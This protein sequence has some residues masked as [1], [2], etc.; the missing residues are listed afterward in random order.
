MN[1]LFLLI[2]TT[3]LFYGC[4]STYI[5]QN[6]YLADNQL[7]SKLNEKQ[8]EITL[9]NG[10]IYIGSIIEVNSNYAAWYNTNNS[11]ESILQPTAEIHSITLIDRS[12]GMGTGFGYGFL[13]GALVGGLIGK[14]NEKKGGG[15]GYGPNINFLRGPG[16]TAFGAI[17]GGIC[18]GILGASYGTIGGDRD[19]Y[20]L[21]DHVESIDKYLTVEMKSILDDT[22]QSIFFE[23]KNKKIHLPKSEIIE[24]IEVDNK[25]YFRVNEV[26]YNAYFK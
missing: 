18:G 1:K 4:S 23:W 12:S 6:D 14:G 16:P 20:I 15:G 17:A 19:T 13:S 21:N 24:R 25:I 2:S 10:D 22:K 11:N 7:N 9:T 3:I 26:T 8:C 5:I